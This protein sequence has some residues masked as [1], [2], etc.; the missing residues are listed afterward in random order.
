MRDKDKKLRIRKL[1]DQL[2]CRRIGGRIMIT[3]ALRHMGSDFVDRALLAVA[4][5][6]DFNQGN[7]PYGEHDFG[8]VTVDDVQLY[9]KID[10]YDATSSEGYGSPDP[11]DPAVTTRVMTVMLAADY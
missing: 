2:R 8:A 10:Y 4:A 7:D 3:R 9:W 5:F 11:S 1:N 6:D